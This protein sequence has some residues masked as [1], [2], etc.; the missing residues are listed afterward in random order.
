M[1]PLY[2]TLLFFFF[3][4]AL[5]V[6]H[7]W[8]MNFSISHEKS[9]LVFDWN[10]SDSQINSGELAFYNFLFLDHNIALFIKA[11]FMF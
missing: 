3:Q 1:T 5:A 6:L 11:V 7:L 9:F 8:H 4:V 10:D 2:L